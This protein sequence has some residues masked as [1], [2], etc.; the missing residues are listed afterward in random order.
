MKLDYS[1]L[2]QPVTQADI[3]AYRTA[4]KGTYFALSK[5]LQ[6][7]GIALA[8]V[9]I[10]LVFVTFFSGNGELLL[11]LMPLAMSGII[12]ISFVF[13]NQKK[14][15]RRAKLYKFA[16][17]NNARFISGVKNPGYSGAIFNYADER[18][19]TDAIALPNGTE[20]G[21]YMYASGSG[22]S[23]T[24]KHWGYVRVKLVRKLPHMLLDA[25]SNNIFGKL[26]NLPESFGKQTLSLEGD[27]DKYFTL[28]VPEGYQR[29]ALYALTPD[30]M[31][32]LVDA[33][34]EFD[35]EIVDDEL[36]IYGPAIDL[37]LQSRI[38]PLLA[39]VDRIGTE[40]RDQTDRYHDD[41]TANYAE[42]V[43][44][45]PGRRLKKRMSTLQII[46]SVAVTAYVIFSVVATNH[47]FFQSLFSR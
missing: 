45:E 43:V 15:Q 12:F 32:A 6:V 2:S 39:V 19:I 40:L 14:I 5:P 21:N 44:A 30:V 29:D 26:S 22:R 31:A 18:S 8:V 47:T 35:I 10:A 24:E 34:K 1:A 36:F 41:R 23:R 7:G 38:E 3:D 13:A 25:K 42:N 16:L 33:G 4:Y 11:G 17:A 46:I 9:A 28:Y 20:I 27:F 37:G